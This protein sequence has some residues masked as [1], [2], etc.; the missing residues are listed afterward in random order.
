MLSTPAARAQDAASRTSR[1]APRPESPFGSGL[2]LRRRLRAAWAWIRENLF[3]TWYNGI[4]TVF[5]LGL[6]YLALK[7]GL[8]WVLLEPGGR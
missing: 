2:P 6:L 7:H 1:P 5:T 8:R 3:S 4:L